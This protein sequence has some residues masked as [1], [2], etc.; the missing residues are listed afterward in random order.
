[1]TITHMSSEHI[2]SELR[3]K[4]ILLSDIAEALE[5]SKS[6]VSKVA[7]SQSKSIRVA[8]SIAH[9]LGK[10][11]TEVF[12]EFYQEDKRKAVNPRTERKQQIINAIRTNQPIPD[13]R[14]A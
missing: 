10:P 1:M 11:L 14:I 7:A 6:L 2:Q 9:A 13:T 4:D 12:G 8:E 3:N 5:V